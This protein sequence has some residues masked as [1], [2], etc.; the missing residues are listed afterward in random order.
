MIKKM[1]AADDEASRLYKMHVEDVQESEVPNP[2]NWLYNQK[3]MRQSFEEFLI[4]VGGAMYS[5]AESPFFKYMYFMYIVYPS[6]WGA[7]IN[8]NF[9]EGG[10]WCGADALQEVL[11][12]LA[13]NEGG[14]AHDA[15]QGGGNAARAA[16]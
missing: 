13:A 5:F 12:N 16:S 9:E 6:Q 3:L 8:S 2:L 4:K 11:C 15:E 1:E 14:I 10:V 7:K